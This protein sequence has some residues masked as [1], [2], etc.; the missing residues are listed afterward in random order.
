MN[1]KRAWNRPVFSDDNTSK[2]SDTLKTGFRI[3]SAL[4]LW[5]FVSFVRE[6][7]LPIRRRTFP[8][9]LVK[10]GLFQFLPNPH[11]REILLR[12]TFPAPYATTAP[13]LA[14]R[15]HYSL[16]VYQHLYS[17]SSR[18]RTK[19]DSKTVARGNEGCSFNPAFRSVSRENA[20]IAGNR[21]ERGFGRGCGNGF[22]SFELAAP[23]FLPS[24]FHGKGALCNSIS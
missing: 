10:T 19:K 20:F 18:K 21:V 9:E 1:E 14:L 2:T 12:S 8:A 6:R 23:G 11:S 15:I 16:V 13:N 5:T 22:A 3:G 17:N 24:S 4:H 7:E